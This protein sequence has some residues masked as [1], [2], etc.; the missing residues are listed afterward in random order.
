MGRQERDALR[1]ELRE[2]AEGAEEAAEKE[3]VCILFFDEFDSIGEERGGKDGVLGDDERKNTV[4][5]LLQEFDG[6]NELKNKNIIAIAA[7]NFGANIDKALVRPGRFTKKIKIH[8]P[9]SP[10]QRLDILQKLTRK[11][12][13][14]KGYVFEDPTALEHLAQITPGQT[15][16]DLKAILRGG[17][18]LARR[19]AGRTVITGDDVFESY[20]R[21]SFGRILD[22][23][24]SRE[25]LELVNW[26]EDG[27]ALNAIGAGIDIFIRSAK[28][29]GES[30]GRVVMDPKGFGEILTSKED[31]LKR[32]F[33]AAG[34][35]AA[36]IERSGELGVTGGAKS[37]FHQIRALI[38]QMLSD[39]MI[40]DHYAL[41]PIAM[42]Q[43]HLNEQ[44]PDRW[45]REDRDSCFRCSRP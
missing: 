29:R 33:I 19:D 41:Q 28:P 13:D 34:G 18:D 39:G 7:T 8:P 27:H 22:T 14:E 37:D 20:Q 38:A 11:E 15:G 3:G 30:G 1:E 4:N 5:A 40:E 32:I 17:R 23:P 9:R 6:V 24:M 26:H 45:T 36:E 31:M 10:E 44:A 16:D 35:R 42:R 43:E 12:I 25:Y 2:A 21:H